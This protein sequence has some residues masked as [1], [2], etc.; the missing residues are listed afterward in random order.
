MAA[1]SLHLASLYP[2]RAILLRR[3][4]GRLLRPAVLYDGLIMVQDLARGAGRHVVRLRNPNGLHPIASR[5]DNYGLRL[6][7][8]GD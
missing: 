5:V 7:G 4:F 8:F 6:Y 1:Q 2:K 3:F